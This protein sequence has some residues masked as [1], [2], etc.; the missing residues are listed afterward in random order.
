M[1]V[2]DIVDKVKDITSSTTRLIVLTGGE[3]F[4]QPKISELCWML[5]GNNYKVQIE[6]AGTI[7][8]PNLPLDH[9]NFIVICSPKTGKLNTNLERWIDAYK[10]IIKE[11]N[12]SDD[13]GLPIYSTQVEGVI[14]K[15]ARPLNPTTPIYISPMDEYN[16]DQNRLN[17]LA[18][19]NIALKYGYK[20]SL[21]IHKLLNIP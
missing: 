10:Y 16:E 11:K 18:V 5:L 21:Q 14:Q 17:L 13:D 6:T 7:C 19:R 1:S 8:P 3:P 4:L 20:I 15:L 2:E 12:Y 9:S